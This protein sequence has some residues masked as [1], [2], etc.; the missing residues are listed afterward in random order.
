LEDLHLDERI[1]QFL[2]IANTMMQRSSSPTE[3]MY[4]ARHYSVIPLGPRSGLIS[5]VDGVTPLFG[6]YKR[7]QQRE[8]VTVSL[9]GGQSSTSLQGGNG[10]W[11][12]EIV[13]RNESNW[14]KWQ[15]S[16]DFKPVNNRSVI[17]FTDK[18]VV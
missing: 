14:E 9:R 4:R 2:S 12:S 1:M 16:F 5:W 11:Q 8:T 10:E 17:M 7:W 6:L 3:S 18:N 15:L 13:T